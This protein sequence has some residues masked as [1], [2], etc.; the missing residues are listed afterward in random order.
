V[1]TAT[2][3]PSVWV[4][5]TGYGRQYDRVAFGDDAAVA[6]GLVAIDERGLP[7]FVADAVADPLTGIAAA[8]AVT[9]YREA[10]DRWLIDVSMADV[11]A[12]VTGSDRATPWV[13]DADLVPDPPRAP[14]SSGRARELG[15]DT[16]ATLRQLELA[17]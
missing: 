16:D 17:R 12:W 9:E 5:I 1:L 8:S 11:A 6:G 15:A 7:C 14:G 13:G 3:G 2:P 10:G 4:S